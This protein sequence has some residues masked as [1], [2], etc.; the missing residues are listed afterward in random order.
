[1]GNFF[2]FSVEKSCILNSSMDYKIILNKNNN[3]TSRKTIIENKYF[4]MKKY[5]L[6]V[7]IYYLILISIIIILR[8]ILIIKENYNLWIDTSTIK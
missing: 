8:W 4:L 7:K 3:K 1:M 2:D 5:K 6:L